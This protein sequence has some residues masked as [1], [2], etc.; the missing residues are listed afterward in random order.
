MARPMGRIVAFAPER[1]GIDGPVGKIAKK[2]EELGN[3]VWWINRNGFDQPL[4]KVE[5]DT[6]AKIERG[7]FEW[8]KLLSGARWLITAGPTLISGE[9]EQA[10]WSAA[11]TFSELEGTLN[12][13][14]LSSDDA[15]FIPIWTKIIPRIRQ[16]HII[17]LT[18]KEIR[19]ISAHEEWAVPKN[20][21]EYIKALERIQR[22]TLIPHLVARENSEGGWSAVA[23]SYGISETEN[24]GEGGIS[25]W[26]GKYIH[27]LIKHGHG[28]DA[29]LKSLE[30]AIN[31]H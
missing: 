31:D 17:G 14:I 23:H 1:G 28:T 26:L 24:S 5:Q 11:L 3:D 6:V 13:L 12:A 7:A 22:K 8:R 21:E 20:K 9:D 15:T 18:S 16:F 10:V 30:Y 29:A 19:K 25:D 27:G 4:N 2:I